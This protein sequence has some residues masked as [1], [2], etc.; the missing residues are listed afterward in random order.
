[1]R[2]DYI[3]N[4]LYIRQKMMILP[5]HYIIIYL[6]RV[7]LSRERLFFVLKIYHLYTTYYSYYVIMSRW[8]LTLS[9]L[10]TWKI[11]RSLLPFLIVSIYI[12]FLC[13][14]LAWRSKRRMIL[15]LLPWCQ[16]LLKKS[17]NNKSSSINMLCLWQTNKI[18]TSVIFE[19]LN[20][21]FQN[22]KKNNAFFAPA[23]QQSICNIRMNKQKN[24]KIMS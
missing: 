17:Y 12:F 23:P 9:W 13:S 14:I 18:H 3:V 1:M 21:C 11:S 20:P 8:S 22:I 24:K 10:T 19:K 2:I 7:Y 16:Q 4:Y 6:K 5:I 15:L